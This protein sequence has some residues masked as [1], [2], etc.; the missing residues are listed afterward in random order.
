MAGL[1]L[2]E[3]AGESSHD[4]GDRTRLAVA[5]DAEMAVPDAHGLSS[6]GDASLRGMSLP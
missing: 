1:N 3:G 6:G 4:A 2:G 5:K